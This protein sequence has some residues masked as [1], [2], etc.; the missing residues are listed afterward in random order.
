MSESRAAGLTR[1]L[2]FAMRSTSSATL[3]PLDKLLAKHPRNVACEALQSFTLCNILVCTA[4]VA[5]QAYA[6]I[7]LVRGFFKLLLYAP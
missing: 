5:R 6:A 3:A 7:A 2:Y 1:Q 4:S